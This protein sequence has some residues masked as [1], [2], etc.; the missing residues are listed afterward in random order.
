M[1]DGLYCVGIL[2]VCLQ[3]CFVGKGDIDTFS[4]VFGRGAGWRVS[5]W[6]EHISYYLEVVSLHIGF[7]G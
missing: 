5:G 2:S 4:C 7:K 3:V 6:G 1:L